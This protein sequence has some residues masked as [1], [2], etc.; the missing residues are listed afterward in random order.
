VNKTDDIEF[1]VKVALAGGP[2]TLDGLEAGDRFVWLDDRRWLG[3]A[4]SN[5]V[6]NG[7]VKTSCDWASHNHGGGCLIEAVVR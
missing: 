2:L 6:R 3:V 7:R 4:I 1:E 5:M